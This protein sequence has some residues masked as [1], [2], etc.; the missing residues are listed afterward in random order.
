MI[1]KVLLEGVESEYSNLIPNTEVVSVLLELIPQIQ[2]FFESRHE[3]YGQLT[4][5]CWLLG[6]AFLAHV[7][8][9]LYVSN[10]ELQGRDKHTAEM[11]SSLRAFRSKLTLWTCGIK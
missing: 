6:L 10:L 8:L 2:E 11:I 5:P 4:D 1:F 7:T 9:E 3:R